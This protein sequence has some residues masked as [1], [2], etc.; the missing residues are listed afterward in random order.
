MLSGAPPKREIAQSVADLSARLTKARNDMAQHPSMRSSV[1]G[2][3]TW[4]PFDAAAH[5]GNLIGRDRRARQ[6]RVDGG[7]NVSGV[8]AAL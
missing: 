2:F 8:H 7:A 3:V 6:H 1:A 5:R 4:L